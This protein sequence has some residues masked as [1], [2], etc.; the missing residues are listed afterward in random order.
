MW[1]L[2]LVSLAAALTFEDLPACDREPVPPGT[3]DF[4]VVAVSPSS[5]PDAIGGHIALWQRSAAL[6]RDHFWQYGMVRGSN[7]QLS[8]IVLGWVPT[9]WTLDGV[10]KELRKYTRQDRSV[11]ALKLD[12]PART[13][14]RLQNT[15]TQA[16][17]TDERTAPWDYLDNNCSTAIRDVL[18]EAF[19][20]QLAASL[21][22]PAGNTLL[23]DVLR[24]AGVLPWAWAGLA[25]GHGAPTDQDLGAWRHAAFSL[26]LA[27]HLDTLML[28]GAPLVT[29]RC[30]LL[31]GNRALPPEAPPDFTGW[32]AL[33]GLGWAAGIGGLS[34]LPGRA[35]RIGAAVSVAGTS[36]LLALAG[37]VLWVLASAST[38]HGWSPSATLAL[39]QPGWAVGLGAAVV[40]AR[41]QRKR[42]LGT[43]G[44]LAMVTVLIAPLAAA[45]LEQGIAASLALFGPPLVAFG[46]VLWLRGRPRRS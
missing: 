28:D 29:E 10:D 35:G 40:L 14:I 36:L 27:D 19:E 22:V 6:E 45:T 2:A 13:R 23:D 18:D 24:H 5:E 26:R 37:T 3:N 1:S 43:T 11:V 42:W 39:L 44:G 30:L 9:W 31:D 33:L 8:G 16:K 38:W 17:K 4:Y 12:L 20:G 34:A 7:L 21:D 15:L 25:I 46:A 41:G 32:L